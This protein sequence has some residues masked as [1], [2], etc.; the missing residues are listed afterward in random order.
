MKLNKIVFFIVSI[1]LGISTGLLFIFTFISMNIAERFLQLGLPV[2]LFTLSIYIMSFVII[3]S[4]WYLI[5]MRF[6]SG[7]R[8]I[9]VLS[10]FVLIAVSIVSLNFVLNTISIGPKGKQIPMYA[11][12][13]RGYELDGKLVVYPPWEE[14][15]WSFYEPHGYNEKFSLKYKER[16]HI[17]S[18]YYP[19]KQ[20][21]QQAFEEYR[22]L[23]ISNGFNKSSFDIKV[24]NTEKFE[25]ID[26]FSFVNNDLIY[27]EFIET[28]KNYL[29]GYYIIIIKSNIDEKQIIK[30]I[31]NHESF[32][33]P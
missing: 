11:L 2:G 26:S 15:D 1:I 7:D 18:F 25:L 9:L 19:D 33:N 8:K 6:Y 27:S 21:A 4:V 29:P 20:K 22:T 28:K 14:Y 32:K 3:I 13:F 17:A 12:I 5:S 16:I 10:F 30:T 23:I 31:V 24:N